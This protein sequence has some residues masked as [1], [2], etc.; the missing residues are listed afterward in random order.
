MEDSIVGDL[1]SL[2]TG[3]ASKYD[4]FWEVC[5][6]FLSEESAVDDRHHGEIT[7]LA[8]ALSVRDLVEQVKHRCSPNILIPSIEWVRL[9]FWP[10][11]PSAKA[12]M[13]YTGRLK[14]RFMIQQ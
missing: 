3:Q 13:H 7:H 5:D 9:Q 6:I 1:R 8:H 2:N 10:K 11:T 12:T 14:V 4:R